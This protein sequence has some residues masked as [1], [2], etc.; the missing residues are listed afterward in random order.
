MPINL[1]PYPDLAGAWNPIPGLSPVVSYQDDLGGFSR[2]LAW[3]T[4]DGLTAELWAAI[5][6]SGRAAIRFANS[7]GDLVCI[8]A[9][10][11]LAAAVELLA[12]ADAPL[13]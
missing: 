12:A 9:F 7:S 3:E 8:R 5:D 6:G 2:L 11:T 10:N 13:L 4:L 1:Q